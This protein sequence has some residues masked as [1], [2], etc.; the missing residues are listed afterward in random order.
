MRKTFNWS[1]MPN[2]EHGYKGL[3]WYARH[4]FQTRRPS[5]ILCFWEKAMYSD[6]LEV[7]TTFGTSLLQPKNT[8]IN[9]LAATIVTQLLG[10]ELHDFTPYPPPRID[11]VS[12]S[13]VL[14]TTCMRR[15]FR[16]PSSKFPV[17]HTPCVHGKTADE[18]KFSSC[19]RISFVKRS[20]LRKLTPYLQR[21]KN[22]H[23]FVIQTFDNTL[24]EPATIAGRSFRQSCRLWHGITGIRNF[25]IN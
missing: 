22:A 9:L 16:A 12:L 11:P 2:N 7:T 1:Y 19:I 15:F 20:P 18:E 23:I 13:C 10:A 5:D 25:G 3:T 4:E 21:W 14:D 8:G 6:L 24:E 17:T